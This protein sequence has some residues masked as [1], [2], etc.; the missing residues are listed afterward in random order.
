MSSLKPRYREI[1]VMRC[2]EEMDYSEIANELGCTE[3][4]A[5][6]LFFRAKRA[7]AKALSKRGLDGFYN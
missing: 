3:F 2:Y 6:V 4:G 1:L 5:R 7:L